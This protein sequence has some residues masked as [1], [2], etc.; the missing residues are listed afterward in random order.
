MDIK[1]NIETVK[2]LINKAALKAKRNPYEITLVGVTKLIDVE[3]IKKAMECGLKDFG[4]NYAQ[5]FRD[6]YSELLSCS[7]HINWHFIGTLQRNKVKYVVGKTKL[8]HSLCNLRVAEELNKK[9]AE[10][11]VETSVLIEVNMAGEKSKSGIS[12]NEVE[13]F[14][15]NIKKMEHLNIEGLMTMAPYY[16]DAEKTRPIF[17]ALRKLR[18]K[19]RE[20][21]P[22]IYHLSMG[23]SNDFDVAIEEGATIVRIGTAIFGPREKK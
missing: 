21:H 11:E 22:S 1:K 7:T 3:H 8:I 20:S 6:K 19:L 15:S 16:K 12:P 10:K 23:M 13:D 14:I 4:E 2:E 17:S 9:S 18:D 5:E